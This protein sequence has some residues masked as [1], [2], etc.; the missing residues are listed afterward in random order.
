MPPNTFRMSLLNTG[1]KRKDF[2]D[3]LGVPV[4]IILG[5]VSIN[6]YFL[7]LFTLQRLRIWISD[8]SGVVRNWVCFQK[9]SRTFEGGLET[10]ILNYLFIYH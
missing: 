7:D 10:T 6:K 4:F 9:A 8:L 3:R 1:E 5:D 2:F